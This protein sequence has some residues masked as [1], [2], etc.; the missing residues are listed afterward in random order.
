MRGRRDGIGSG[1]GRQGSCT[2]TRPGAPAQS[3]R[4]DGDLL[5]PST[6]GLLSVGRSRRPGAGKRRLAAV[7]VVGAV[8]LTAAACGK[9][10]KAAAPA[11]SAAEPGRSRIY[12][13]PLH[14]SA[15]AVAEETRPQHEVYRVALSVNGLANY[16]LIMAQM[17][18]NVPYQGLEW[19]S[20]VR[21]E[22]PV[23]AFERVWRKPS[24]TD[25]LVLQG[26]AD[27]T[28]SRLV[29]SE[30]RGNAARQC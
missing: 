12:D 6:P 26:T 17:G 29:I 5:E 19:C 15:A 21:T 27:G 28:G 4:A 9:D 16:Y 11:A 3:V 23:R 13:I 1:E 18:D 30:E 7:G 8:L 10:T 14:Q 2:D 25:F 24:T 20:G 22:T